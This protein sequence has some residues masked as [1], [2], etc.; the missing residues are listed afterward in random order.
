MCTTLGHA[1]LAGNIYHGRTLE[2]DVE[3]VYAVTYVP[4]G[5]TFTSHAKDSAPAQ[6]EAKHPFI[7]VGA[8]VRKPTADKPLTQDDVKVIEGLNLAGLAFSML[9]FPTTAGVEH[10]RKT[11]RA[12][13]DA[14]DIGSWA[15][16]SFA[17]TA[18]LKQ[19]IEDNDFALTRLEAV[20]NLPFPFHMLI[21]D[22]AG[23]SVVIEWLDGEMTVHDNPVGVMTNGPYFQW[24][25]TNISNYTHMSN[26]DVSAATFGGLE[27]RQPDSGIATH[28][29]PS[30]N[31]SVGRF[32][33]ALYY[34]TFTEKASD[35]DLA[36]SHLARIMN[37]FDRPRGVTIT[38]PGAE[39]EGAFVGEQ[40]VP[41]A[42][43][44]EYTAWTNLSD[45]SR[46][47]L[48]VRE[49]H[50]FNYT[51]FDLQALSEKNEIHIALMSQFSPLG[52]DGTA[53]MI[54]LPD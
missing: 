54:P 43:P 52:G 34:T 21:R 25:I 6:Y 13:I 10:A 26:V 28:S 37:N 19:G 7:A 11:T 5:T 35:P 12:L 9:A 23:K 30:S 18:E 22:K 46:S 27:A 50:A 31:T 41:G 14:V 36:M 15:L 20:G 17:D 1:D 49:Y 38:P 33:K 51:S 53:A 4:A 29:I 40:M 48:L 45:L 32:M 3:E 24:H 2:L 16:A 39:G 47:S 44:T 8:P 42:P